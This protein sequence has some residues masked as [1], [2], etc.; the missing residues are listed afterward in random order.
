MIK[1]IIKWF[2]K[3]K[4]QTEEEFVF[5]VCET[6]C[7][8]DLYRYKV[9]APNKEEAFK[10]LVKFFFSKDGSCS[11]VRSEHFNVSSNRSGF[12]Y[13]NMPYWFA[14]RISGYS[15]EGINDYQKELEKY[16]IENDIEL[17]NKNNY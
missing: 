7:V 11:D 13:H 6:V 2:Q 16:A 8:G 9:K 10:K 17:S 1:D 14:K 3:P 4:P 5:D 15:I 12:T